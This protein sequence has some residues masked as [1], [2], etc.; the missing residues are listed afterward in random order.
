M[1]LFEER[2]NSLA[3][4]FRWKTPHLLPHLI[5]ESLRE[6]FFFAGKKR[7][8]HGADGQSRSARNFLRQRPHFSFELR[9]GNHLIEK[10][11]SECGLRIN[12]IAGLEKLRRFRRPN[13]FRKKKRPA[14]IGK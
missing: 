11:N 3:A 5:V 10:P 6:F 9:A 14:I 4:V 8:L 1:P 2:A 13:Q 7:S 12:Q